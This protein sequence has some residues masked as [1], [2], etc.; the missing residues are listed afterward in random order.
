MITWGISANSHDAALAVFKDFK[1]EFASQSERFSKIKNDPHLNKEILDYALQYGYPNEII[2]YESPFKKTLRQ[3]WAGQGWNKKENDIKSYISNF[4]VPQIFNVPIKYES[5]HRSHAASGYFTSGFK[6]A[7]IIVLDS[8]GEWET[9]TIWHAEGTKLKKIFTQRY[10]HSIGLWY[11]SMTKRIGLKPN[12]EEYILMGMAAYG[13]KHRLYQTI[14]N[15]FFNI[16]DHKDSI[17]L[18]ENLHRGCKDWR[19]DLKTEQDKFDIAAGTQAVYEYIL[20]RISKTA[21]WYS[22]SENLVL[23]GGCALN[24]SANSLL[25]NDWKKIYV[26]PYPGDCGS[27]IGAVLSHYNKHTSI[28]PYLGYNIEKPYPVK[29]LIKE[30][31][32]TGI[33]GVANGP[34]E[35]GPRALGNRSLLADPRRSDIKD[36]VNE[37]KQREKFRPFA[38]AILSEHVD[39]YFDG[40]TG[41]Y[42]QF[43]APCLHPNSIPSVVHEDG[44]SRVQT[45]SKRDNKGFRKLL[46]QWYKETGCPLLLNT[47]LNIKGMPIVNDLTDAKKFATMYNVKVYS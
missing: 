14:L 17:R 7:T 35:F 20:K 38:P 28:Q 34:A 2:W 4:S 12:E 13:N 16:K 6:N 45:V 47:S 24:C 39:E 22:R 11:S 3:W 29:R 31:K 40:V 41:P 1:I 37:I 19:R 27:A 9:F 15:D 32:T 30:L 43:T 44:T 26:P 10:P 42:M 8:I 33:V 5:H 23:S 25:E 21:K 18:K 46:E 36:K